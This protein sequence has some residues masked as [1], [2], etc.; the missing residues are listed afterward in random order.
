MSL[1]IP[2]SDWRCFRQVRE[3]L[4]ERYCQQVLDELSAVAKSTEGTSHQRYLQAYKLLQDR[5]DALAGAFND[6]RRSTA[7]TQ[8]AIMREME[9]LTKKD[10]GVFSAQTQEQVRR[11]A[12]SISDEREGSENYMQE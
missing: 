1:Q 4:L 11:F 10:L 7:L 5:D 3:V 2:E 9:L 8:L 12:S 6:P